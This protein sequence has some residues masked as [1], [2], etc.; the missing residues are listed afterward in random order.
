MRNSVK[1]Y[2]HRLPEY[3]ERFTAGITDNLSA[4]LYYLIKMA[5][6][7][8]KKHQDDITSTVVTNLEVAGAFLCN[9][10]GKISRPDYLHSRDVN[11][12]VYKM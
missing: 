7:L 10:D 8:V 2:H 1:G 9:I 5:Q 3:T 6:A 11:F 12:F 4:F